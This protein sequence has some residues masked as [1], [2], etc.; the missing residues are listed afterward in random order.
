MAPET[1]RATLLSRV[2]DKHD[3]SSW[4]EFDA[5]Y[6]ALILRYCR[7]SGL[8]E[9]DAEDVR[10]A[11]M[12]RLAQT[13]QSF[14]YRPE[15]GRFRDYLR[16]AVRNEI[17][18]QLA[19]RA[20]RRVEGAVEA[21]EALPADDAGEVDEAWEAEWR[22]HHLRVAMDKARRSFQGPALAIFEGLLAGESV[23][24]VAR[25]N[26]VSADVVYKSKS[27]VRDFLRQRIAEQLREEEFPELG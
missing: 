18:A 15:L 27:R 19:A 25:S 23:E 16:R 3:Q 10:Q 9:S 12:L 4:R 20:R 14:T 26:G 7:R 24:R 22:A 13:M 21:L 8:Q 6:R 11:L 5:H 2:R 1:T 17:S